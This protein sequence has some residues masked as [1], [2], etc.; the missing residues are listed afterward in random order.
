MRLKSLELHGFKSFPER[1][2]MNFTQGVTVIVGPNGS[3]KSNI[4]DA[5]RWVLGELSSKSIRGTKMSDV[6]FLGTETRPAMGYAEVSLTIDNT[7]EDRI[8]SEYDEITVTRRLYRSGDSEYL[9]NNKVSRLRDILNLFFNTGIGK[10][11]YSIIGQGRIAEII[12]Q[13]SEDRRIIFEEAAGISKFRIQKQD[14]ERRLRDVDDNMLRVTDILS[15]IEGRVGPLEKESAKAKIYLELYEKKKA[16]EVALAVY[17]IAKIN[18][19]REVIE[20]DCTVAAEELAIVTDALESLESR[21]TRITGLQSE[22]REELER[23]TREHTE[24]L[25]KRHSVENELN[26]SKFRLGSLES[27]DEGLRESKD[28]ALRALADKKGELAALDSKLESEN[29]ALDLLNAAYNETEAALAK[30]REELIAAADL[31]EKTGAERS[32]V[33]DRLGQIKIEISAQDATISSSKQRRDEIGQEMSA[34]R[35]RLLALSKKKET[36]EKT[37]SGFRERAAGLEKNSAEASEDCRAAENALAER[38][39]A[40]S[41]LSAEIASKEQRALTLRRMEEHFEGYSR[42]VKYIAEKSA[43]GE[44]SGICGPVSKLISTARKYSLAVETT[45]GANIQNIVVKDEDAAKAAIAM[46]KRDNIGRATFYPLTTIRSGGLNVDRAKLSAMNGYI[47][48]A[49]ELVEYDPVYSQVMLYLLGRTAVFDTLDNASRA[50]GSFGY[51]FRIVTLDGQLINAG[52]S[53]TGGAAKNDSGILTRSAEISDIEAQQKELE[54]KATALRNKIAELERTLSDK[55][56]ELD[57]IG[58][59][60][61]LVS[62]LIKAEETSL[63]ILERGI[64]DERDKLGLIT[65]SLGDIDREED[66]KKNRLISL[67]EKAAELESE[68]AKLTRRLENSGADQKAATAK[69]DALIDRKNAAYLDCSLKIRDINDLKSRINAANEA[70]SS[71]EEE[72]VLTGTKLADNSE[73]RKKLSENCKALG[74]EEAEIT[75]A[76]VSLEEKSKELDS[77]SEDLEKEVAELRAASKE[78]SDKKLTMSINHS[79]L[80]SRLE[81]ITSDRDKLTEKLLEEYELT[82]AAAKD[83]GYEEITEENRGKKNS[84]LTKYRSKIRELGSVNVSAIEEYKEVKERYDFM[85]EQATDLRKSR[86]DLQEVI[87]GLEKEMSEKFVTAFNE[88]NVAFKDVFTKLFGGGKANLYLSDPENVLTS[89]IEIEA[90]PPGKLLKGLEPLSGGEKALVAIAVFF[91]ILNVNPSPFCLLDEIDTALDEVNVDRFATYAKLY[92]DNTQFIIITH[93]RGAMEVADTLYGVTM[94]EK[95]ISKIL[96]INLSEIEQKTGVT[97]Q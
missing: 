25:E 9:I 10:T 76:I 29:A 78:K 77:E 7:G 35:E 14:A 90:A 17:D 56:S 79:S 73:T 31:V 69:V 21:I 5:I 24:L 53:Y 49:S 59:D 86:V 13:K 39:R 70:I 33:S 58:T 83:L 91:A 34:A 92:S 27:S 11:G 47:G 84:E 74:K 44:L 71:L 95:G 15:E 55:R 63:S 6:I 19:D 38:S 32:E 97:A 22:K 2:K 62:A 42:S 80:T 93:K 96:N 51:S 64:S 81:R 65:G 72:I 28:K 57:G 61:A 41:E 75:A 82:L 23:Q 20:R 67:R 89:G 94:Q 12:S 4:S 45:L 68:I 48:I 46:L 40:L 66:D 1:T 85:T 8:D 87:T 18:A 37:L 43:A 3:G 54:K 88:I 60:I 50:A 26:L 36:S 52:G 30:A 16:I